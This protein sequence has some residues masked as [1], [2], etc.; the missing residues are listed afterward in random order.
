MT[1]R[2]IIRAVCTA[3]KKGIQ[4]KDIGKGL[5]ISGKGLEG[6]GHFGFAHRQV[7]LLD[8]S[9]IE[10]MKKIIPSLFYGAFAENLVTEGI[11]LK[12]LVLGDM[13]RIGKALLRVTQIGKE[14]HSRCA[15][16]EAAG[17]CIMPRLGIFCEVLSGGPV[18]TGDT[19]EIVPEPSG[20]CIVRRKILRIN[21]GNSSAEEDS[22][23]RESRITLVLDGERQ[24]TAAYTPGEERYWAVGHL[25]CR[26]LISDRNDIAS[27]E[28]APGTVSINRKAVTPGLP[29]LNRILSSSASAI[30]MGNAEKRLGDP[31]PAEW[32]IAPSILQD[33]ADWL[34]EAPVFRA[35]GG[36]HAAALLHKS[37]RRLFLTEDIG[38]HNAVDKAAGW[39]VLHNIPLSETILIISGRLPEDMVIKAAG[40]GIP[41]LG[42]ISA[43]MAEG[44]ELASG[45]G[46][47]LAGF[48]RNGRMNVYSVPERIARK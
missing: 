4:K 37:G 43:A 17:D 30:L 7:S 40:A 48:I 2:G 25:K 8:A 31:I 12:A 32:T 21:G 36:T 41:V 16:Y 19:I 20:D 39:A 46:I 6:D 23:L 5:L 22:M 9:E 28:I 44:A 33:G 29:L 15:I 11:D 26:R 38:R 10:R 14:C 34:A 35:T 3:P 47:T 45:Q 18:Q 24:V 13:L 1:S 27:M 42:S